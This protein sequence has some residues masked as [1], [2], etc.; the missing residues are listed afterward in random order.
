MNCIRIIKGV[1]F[2]KCTDCKERIVL[3][4]MIETMSFITPSPKMQ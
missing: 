3:K 1:M 2:V 4:R